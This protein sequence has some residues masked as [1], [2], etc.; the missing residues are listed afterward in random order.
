LRSLDG[1]YRE[2]QWAGVTGLDAHGVEVQGRLE[3]A[4]NGAGLEAPESNAKLCEA[5]GEPAC[6][7]LSRSPGGQ[8]ML[9]DV[10]HAIE[11]GAGAYYH[12]PRA[13]G[14]S[15]MCQNPCHLPPVNDDIGGEIL[16]Q[17]DVGM[18]FQGL[19]HCRA[20]ECLVG[21]GAQG[22]DCGALGSIEYAGVSIGA[23]AVAADFSAERV[24]FRD[25]L[26]LAR[27]AD[28]AIAGHLSDVVKADRQEED[29]GTNARRGQ[30]GFTA[31]VPGTDYNNVIAI[32]KAH[33]IGHAT[34]SIGEKAWIVNIH[35]IL[36][37]T[38]NRA[39]AGVG[40][41][42]DYLLGYPIGVT[43]YHNW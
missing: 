18:L 11:E 8:G 43:Y 6:W 21:L 30:S 29:A 24:N 33:G 36:G 31:S 3:Q 25:Q 4:G 20:I 32:R 27:A 41:R 37:L 35:S 22:L 10:D 39:Y 1:I 26:G 40:E 5:G 38:A 13:E 28:A 2:T 34:K 23:I 19:L 12:C 9:A 42:D 7:H 14:Q 15:G 16:V 17:A